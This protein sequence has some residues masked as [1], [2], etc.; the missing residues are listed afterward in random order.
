M[1]HGDTKLASVRYYVHVLLWVTLPE[2]VN[3][4]H[5]WMLSGSDKNQCHTN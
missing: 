4:A 5:F 2:T 1:R 3:E